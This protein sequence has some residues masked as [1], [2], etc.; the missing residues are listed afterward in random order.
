MPCAAW[1]TATRIGRLILKLGGRTSANVRLPGLSSSLRCPVANVGVCRN[2]FDWPT[3]LSSVNVT[4]K[5]CW[6][7]VRTKPSSTTGYPSY[8]TG[9]VSKNVHRLV[10]ETF[11]RPLM[12]GECVLHK[13]DNRKCANPDHLFSGSKADNNRDRAEKGRSSQGEACHLAKLS[14][15]L[16]MKIY[17][18]NG[19]YR[20]LARKY[21]LNKGTVRQIKTKTTWRHLWK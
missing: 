19:S 10:F 5:G 15:Q 12:P 4:E 7:W 14:E 2:I 6:E 16:V 17:H 11:I 1:P 9:G 8:S 21:G 3:L 13:C 18:E 20:G